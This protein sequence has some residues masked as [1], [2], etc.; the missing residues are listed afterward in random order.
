MKYQHLFGPVASRRLGVSLGVDL[1]VHK[2]CSLDCVYC[3]CGRTT[4]LTCEKKAWV[5]LDRVIAELDHYWTH[6]DDPDYITF[7]GSGEPTLNKDIGTVIA[8]I[9][10]VKPD[11]RVAVLTNATLL[12][13]PKV[14][15]DLSLA[16]LVVP[17]LDAVSPEA[18]QKLNR[19]HS[20]VSPDQV[21]LGIEAFTRS[22]KGT[23]NL[24]IFILPGVNDTPEELAQLRQAADRIAPDM[25]QLN[26]L[27]RPGTEEGL[28]PADRENLE[29]IRT[30]LGPD[31]TEIIA[32]LPQ[33][34]RASRKA[35]DL[36]AAV[37]ET[38][39][40]RPCTCMD[41]A[42]ML[43]ADAPTVQAL[44]DQLETKGEILSRKGERGRFYQT[45]KESN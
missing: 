3:E 34:D 25:I 35:A 24:E 15:A 19:P 7:S 39:L 41:L 28:R 26:S 21:I 43:G 11:I 22:F 40:R 20:G 13:D 9:K 45:R 23:V 30:V 17:S 10:R 38:I 4:E 12:S 27:D 1:V 18:F 2:V 8:H 29:R 33:A 16:D 14:R 37:L 42:A 32:R 36:E 5:P 44:L 6:Q 31:R